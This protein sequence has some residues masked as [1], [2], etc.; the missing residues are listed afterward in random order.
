MTNQQR[1]DQGY[2]S[3]GAGL[4]NQVPNPFYGIITDPLA[5]VLNKPTVQLMQLLYPYPQFTSVGAWP[6]PP[7][8][9]SIYNAAQVKYTKRYSHGFN[10]SA[11]YTLSKMI[12]DNSLG[13]SGQSWLGGQTPIQHYGNVRLERAVSVRDIT[14]RGVMDFLYELPI[15]KGKLI[16]NNWKGPVDAALGGWQVNGI[17]V[18]QS[19]AP[20]IPNLQSGVLPGATQR[21]NLLREPGLPGSVVSRIDHYLDPDAFS[22]PDPYKFGNAPRTMPR[23]RG[24]GLR[25]ADVSLF[26]NINIKAERSIYAQLRGEAFNVTN[27]PIFADPNVTFGSTSFGVITG[28]QNSPRTLQVALKI[29]F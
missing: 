21:P 18:L 7:I 4:N 3:L 1:I 10:V 24:P 9:D 26:K 27:S 2:Y 16:G 23:T 14:H 6:A 5:T 13:S 25:N 19:G 28:T 20:L 12:D 15:G 22:R 11:H 29:N 8:A 17:F